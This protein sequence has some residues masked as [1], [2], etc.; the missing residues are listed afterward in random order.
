MREIEENVDAVIELKKSGGAKDK[1][2]ADE[3][4]VAVAFLVPAKTKKGGKP[5][6]EN[7]LANQE[8]EESKSDNDKKKKKKGAKQ[9]AEDLDSSSDQSNKKRRKKNRR[10][11]KVEEYGDGGYINENGEWI[12][13]ENQNAEGG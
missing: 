3:E 6:K 2:F 4:N 13:P 8:S 12:P 1:K 9:Y 5:T 7:P 11:E 10:K